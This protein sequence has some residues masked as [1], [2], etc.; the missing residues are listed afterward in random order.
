MH[1]WRPI[2]LLI[3]MI[4]IPLVA[5]ADCPSRYEVLGDEGKAWLGMNA[6][7][8]MA[9]EGQSFT[10]DCTSEVHSVEFLMILD[11]LTWYGVQPLGT[12]DILYGAIMTTSGLTLATETITLDFDE[13]T[14]WITF[15]FSSHELELFGGEYLI[16][17][18]P[19]NAKQARMSYHQAE[20]IYGAGL[21]YI[22]SNGGAGPWTPA[23]PEHG[24]LAFRVNMPGFV[25]NEPLQWGQVKSLYH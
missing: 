15:D 25:A 20:D 11:G 10:L 4:A 16:A 21:R 7:G 19:A 1:A 5:L 9:G 22:S 24:D 18:Y 8:F 3:A 17:C 6:G 13:G 2:V 14:R 12:G 23:A